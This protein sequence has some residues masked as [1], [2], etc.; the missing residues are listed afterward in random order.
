MTNGIVISTSEHTKDFL[1]DCLESLKD[2]EQPILVVG[3]DGFTPEVSRET[4]T[5]DWNGFELGAILRGAERFD[6]FIYLPD[7]CLVHDPKFIDFVFQTD[8]AVAFCDR[9]MG[10]FGKYRTEILRKTGIPKITTKNEAVLLETYWNQ[11]YLHTDGNVKIFQPSVPIETDIFETIHGKSRMVC[12]NGL[13]TK[14][15]GTY[16]GPAY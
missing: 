8:D 2:V 7:T 4:I 13:I 12:S 3:N 16:G 11:T 1:N 14:F 10:Y 15:K 9:F 5:N 6:R